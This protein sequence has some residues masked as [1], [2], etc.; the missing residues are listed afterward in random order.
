MAIVITRFLF[1]DDM[2]IIN[3]GKSVNTK[4][5]DLSQQNQRVVNIWESSLWSTDGALRPDKLYWYMLDYKHS[6]HEW[7]YWLVT[8]LPK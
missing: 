5:E 3:T 6:G 2:E 8:Q 4:G 1:V 7:V